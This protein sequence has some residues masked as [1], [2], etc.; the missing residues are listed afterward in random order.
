MKVGLVGVMRSGKTTVA[1]YLCQ[2]YGFTRIK[3]ADPLKDMLRSLGLNEDEIEGDL[4]MQPCNL[5]M[6]QTPRHAMQT[7]GTEWGRNMIH[8]NLWTRAWSERAGRHQLVV[9]DD[10]RFP[11]EVDEIRRQAGKLIR[12]IPA[13]P[14]YVDPVDLHESEAYAASMEVDAEIINDGSIKQLCS[15]VYNAIWE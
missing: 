7:L 4:K 15:T 14:G 11:N 1:D 3:F 10:C 6:G 5:L 13:Y 2:S 8:P 9:A 12:I